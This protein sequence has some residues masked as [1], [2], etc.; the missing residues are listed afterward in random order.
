MKIQTAGDKAITLFCDVPRGSPQRKVDGR[1]KAA[2]QGTAKNPG[3]NN[4]G[5][6][7]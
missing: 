3:G 6:G 1:C 7:L 2:T 5:W 4:G